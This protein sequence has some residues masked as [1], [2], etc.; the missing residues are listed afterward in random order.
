MQPRKECLFRVTAPL[1]IEHRFVARSANSDLKFV[2]RISEHGRN[3]VSDLDPAVRS[4]KYGWT[5]AQTVKDFAEEPF[6][7]V[8]AAAFCE[9]LRATFPGAR[10]NLRRFLNTR[11][12]L[13]KPRHCSRLFR[14]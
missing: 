3:P 11:V 6:A 13:P 5:G 1:C 7:A 12:I 8:S 2:L 4:S 10:G 9:V 14:E